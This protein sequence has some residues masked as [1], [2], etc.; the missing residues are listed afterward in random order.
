MPSNGE[1]SSEDSLDHQDDHT[2]ADETGREHPL[3]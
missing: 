2:L 1:V 3:S